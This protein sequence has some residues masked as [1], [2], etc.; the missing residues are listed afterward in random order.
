[1]TTGDV[2]D[3]HTVVVLDE[4]T[5]LA[6]RDLDALLREFGMRGATLR[7]V[8]DPAQHS[9]VGA[10]GAFR[11]LVETNPLDVAELTANHRQVG[12]DMGEVRL[13][14]AEYHDGAIAAAMERLARDQRIVTAG[15]AGDLLDLM[16]ADWYVDRQP[17]ATDPEFGRS[18]MTA[19]HH[20]ERRAL[21]AR[22]RALL[23][24]DGTLHGP[25]LVAAGTAFCAGDEVMAKVPNR[26][27]R[28]ERGDRTSYVKNGTRGIVVSVGGA[29]LVV[30][31][32]H[33][34]GI[35]VP[36]TYLE[37]QIAPVVRGGLFHSY[38]LTT[39][40]AEGDTYGAARH[41]GTDH[42]SRA[43]LYVGL[44]RGRHD[45]TL[46]AVG[47]EQLVGQV[48]EDDLPRLAVETMLPGPWLPQ[49][50]RAEPNAWP[51]RWTR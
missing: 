37:Q 5:T 28:P 30:D 31:F 12:G 23:Q 7:L 26:S 22:A 4:A 13:A 49:L 45:V 32:E 11:W 40:A 34:G 16:T 10:G 24:A 27:L 25:E 17:A 48:V 50:P 35:T 42:S 21:V 9:A 3:R 19:A 2:V 15:S 44:T 33:R 8:G 14:L 41:L 6:N 38:C 51:R 43:E 39:Y 20:D 29:H 46:Y 47:R 18:S 36:R 1:M